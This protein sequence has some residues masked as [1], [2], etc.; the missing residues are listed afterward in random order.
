MAS[1]KVKAANS[2]VC[3]AQSTHLVS[4]RAWLLPPMFLDP[5]GALGN[6]VCLSTHAHTPMLIARS[7]TIGT[8]GLTGP[9]RNKTIVSGAR[10]G[11]VQAEQSLNYS[12]PKPCPGYMQYLQDLCHYNFYLHNTSELTREDIHEKLFK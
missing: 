2:A 10:R 1:L 5:P 8:L 12:Y 6:V 4:H 7:G 11:Q 9:H 3:S